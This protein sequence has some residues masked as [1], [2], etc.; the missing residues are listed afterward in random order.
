MKSKKDRRKV[1]KTI[2]SFNE[3]SV[4]LNVGAS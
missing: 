3:L 2:T 1:K 4:L